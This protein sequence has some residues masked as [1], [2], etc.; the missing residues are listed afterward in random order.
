VRMGNCR[1][2]SV[3]LVKIA[4]MGIVC[5]SG[6]RVATTLLVLFAG[7]HSIMADESDGMG[8]VGR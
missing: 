5:S 2:R 1:I 4:F 8:W 7:I 3:G 6:L